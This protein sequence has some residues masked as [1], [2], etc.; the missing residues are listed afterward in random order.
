MYAIFSGSLS[1]G[2]FT[3]LQQ[4]HQGRLPIAFSQVQSQN[5]SPDVG[6]DQKA[7]RR[8]HQCLSKEMCQAYFFPHGAVN[9]AVPLQFMSPQPD[10]QM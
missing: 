3:Y 7:L 9:H 4:H 8:P 6:Y 2:L 10:I 1:S 5:L